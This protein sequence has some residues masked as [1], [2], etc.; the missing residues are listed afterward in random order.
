MHTS[1]I[2]LELLMNIIRGL[3]Y[4]TKSSPSPAFCSHNVPLECNSTTTH[5]RFSEAISCFSVLLDEFYAPQKLASFFFLPTDSV[6]IKKN[7]FICFITLQEKMPFIASMNTLRPCIEIVY[8]WH[9]K[10]KM[11]CY[12]NWS[13]AHILV[14]Q[15]PA[16]SSSSLFTRYT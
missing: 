11:P 8:C 13:E 14:M 10:T 15:S 3:M 1:G 12:F 4:Q 7:C 9:P 2:V 16:L 5:R 6:T